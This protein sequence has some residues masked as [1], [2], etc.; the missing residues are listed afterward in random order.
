[1]NLNLIMIFSVLV[2]AFLSGWQ[3]GAKQSNQ[4]WQKKW[5]HKTAEL[6]ARQHAALVKV[7]VEDARRIN[8]LEEIVHEY[9][10]KNQ[11]NRAAA[12][13]AD[14]IAGRMHEQASRLAGRTSTCSNSA[15]TPDRGEAGRAT[16]AIVLA[17]LFKRSDAV[18]GQLAAGYDRSRAAGLACEKAYDTLRN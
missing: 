6:V 17:E 12:V 7:R 14:A 10:E 18:A 2:L 9:N 13:A 4:S 16:D 15:T 1:M 3:L 11:E 8:E 5:D